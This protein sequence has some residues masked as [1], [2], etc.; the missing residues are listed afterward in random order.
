MA[1]I[2][3]DNFDRAN[4]P[5]SLG[6]TDTGQVWSVVRGP[7][8][9]FGI[10]S[11]NAVWTWDFGDQDGHVVVETGFTDARATLTLVNPT[12]GTRIF[13]VRYGLIVRYVD[14]N[15]FWRLT[16]L[17]A[18]PG[19][20]WLQRTYA[21][22]TATMFEV[23]TT[24]ADNDTISVAYCGDD[25]EVFIND[26]S[27][28]TYND[29]AQPQNY[30]T[31]CGIIGSSGTYFTTIAK[32]FDNFLVETTGTC[33]PT[34]NCTLGA[35][36]DPGDG[37]GTYAVLDDC[38]TAC[39]VAES[40]D[41]VAEEC[42]DPGDGSGDFATLLECQQSGCAGLVTNTLRFDSGDGSNYYLV[43]SVSDSGDE[44]RSKTYKAV[45]LTGRRTNAS[46]RVYGFDVNQEIDVDEL[47]AGTRTNTRMTTNA[48]S[49]SDSTQVS[50]S[51]RKPVNITNAVLGT[52]RI[53]GDDTGNEDRDQ[54]HEIVVEQAQQGVRR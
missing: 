48:Q 23:I 32:R 21:G 38:L 9:A 47:E 16:Y 5:S 4:D 52:V 45:R 31:Q 34:Y 10:N 11:N 3:S 29:S 6:T 51:Q 18:T 37:T 30:G 20:V 40:Y 42:I 36:V 35:C 44:L 8:D 49:F 2:V 22:S 43:A 12:N 17:Q 54:I 46:A 14:E 27:Q 26:V 19:R 41:C 24:L 13:A 15:Y 50:Q 1:I 39:G 28:G 7:S 25:F 53:E 33:T